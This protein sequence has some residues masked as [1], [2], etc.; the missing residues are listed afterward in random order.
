MRLIMRAVLA[1]LVAVACDKT[2]NA[3]TPADGGSGSPGPVAQHA[4]HLK[5]SGSGQIIATNPSFTCSS[6]CSQNVDATA[7]VHLT[8]VAA[9]G[10]NFDG[11]QGDCS[12]TGSCDVAMSSDRDVTATFSSAP[13]PPPGSA[14]VTVT[15]V[16]DGT[17][18]VVS[19]PAGIDCTSGSCSM[20]VPAGSGIA[21]SETPGAN[22][23]FAGWGGDCSGNGG[24]SATAGHDLAI[25]ANF[26]ANPPP[27]PPPATCAVAPP[28]DETMQ[29]YITST[30]L[31]CLPGLGDANG[32]LVFASQQGFMTVNT[33][34]DFVSTGGAVLK[35]TSFNTPVLKPMQQPAGMVSASD[36]QNMGPYPGHGT[37]QV[38]RWDTNGNLFSV[39]T[40]RGGTRAEAPNPHGGLFVAGDLSSDTSYPNPQPEQHVAVMFS[41]GGTS[42]STGVVWGPKPLAAA[43]PVYGAGVDLTG[44]A[45]V[46]TGAGPGQLSAQWFGADGTPLTGEFT[47]DTTFVA[48]QNTWFECSP[49]IGSGLEVRRMDYDSG[50][51]VTTAHALVIVDSG[52]PTVH[53]APAWMTARPNT[54]LQIARGGQAYAVLPYGAQNVACTQR[55]EIVAPDGTSCG[56]RDYGIAA[57]NCN[58]LD[59]QM[60]AD[61]TVIQSLPTGMETFSVNQTPQSHTC[62]WRWWTGAAR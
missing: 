35:N 58:T 60:G 13:P 15:M 54:K 59:L 2:T 39:T 50:T 32:T 25:W 19:T 33:A 49:L 43:G 30:N 48:G 40:W 4:L 14:R 11:W 3:Q 56:S 55:V 21:L 9:A 20:I 16:G 46:I 17:G 37:L 47:L 42:S 61:G 29:Q 24:C 12:G 44:K 5:V 22:S 45:L 52:A 34:I 26:T 1:A 57:G 27:P 51:Q 53:P 28:D 7:T 8:A 36:G 31:S 62:H 41:G 18:H 23:T 10:S 38:G 6:D